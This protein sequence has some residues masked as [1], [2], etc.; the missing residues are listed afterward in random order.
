MS[1]TIAFCTPHG[2]VVSADRCI[3]TTLESGSSFCRTMKERKLFLTP[4]GFAFT[5]AGKSTFSNRPASYWMNRFVSRFSDPNLTVA[6]CTRKLCVAFHSMEPTKNIV[7]IG[8]GYENGKPRVYSSSSSK[9]TLTDHLK[10]G[11]T[12]IAFS[13]ETDLAKVIIDAKPLDTKSYTIPDTI[14]FVKH[15]TLTVSNIQ[16]FGQTPITVSPDCDTLLIED[17]R[18]RWVDPPAFI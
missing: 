9:R 7:I 10:G 17:G 18:S 16:R 15:V 2:I 4:T 3:T 8:A 6:D 12:C 13:G 1:L 5:Y 11:I 14:D